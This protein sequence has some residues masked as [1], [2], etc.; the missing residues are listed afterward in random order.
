MFKEII[1]DPFPH[2]INKKIFSKKLWQEINENWPEKKFFE[3]YADGHNRTKKCSGRFGFYIMGYSANNFFKKKGYKNKFWK[4]FSDFELK[5][6]IKKKYFLFLPYFRKRFEEVYDKVE[7]QSFAVLVYTNKQIKVKVHTENPSILMS[8]LI[9]KNTNL[10]TNSGT[11]LYKAIKE[12]KDSGVKFLNSSNFKI[13]KTIPFKNN[14]E[15]CFIKT[16]N[17]FHG[18]EKT[19]IENN[20]ERCSINWHLR[21]TDKSIEKI[22]KIKKF[23]D[24]ARSKGIHEKKIL[25]QLNKMETE[26]LNFKPATNYEREMIEKS[27]I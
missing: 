16:N 2:T 10:H 15:L 7:L 11:T 4:N 21:L 23:K 1:N 13:F 8:G 5:D 18:V 20:Q 17:S 14:H 3:T 27:F 12:Q 26:E 22:Y 24:F 19:F 6:N 25:Y 9:Y